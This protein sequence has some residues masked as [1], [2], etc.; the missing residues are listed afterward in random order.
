MKPPV[1]AVKVSS[2]GR[3]ILIQAKRLT[4]LTQ[5]N[6][7]LRWAFC[8][9]IANRE[10]P[11]LNQKLDS[12]IEPLEWTTF[13]GPYGE[14]FAA[15]LMIRATRDQVDVNDK[16]QVSLYFR[17]HIERGVASLRGIKGLSGF[18]AVIR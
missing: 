14:Y 1:E 13:S 5:W 8:I 15:A 12:G 9:S 6:E 18:E 7:L 4:G 2:K 10:C 17:A 3:D 16:E 11:K